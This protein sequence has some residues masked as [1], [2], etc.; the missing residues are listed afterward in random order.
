MGEYQAWAATGM[1][2]GLESWSE[3]DFGPEAGSDV[4]DVGAVRIASRMVE[5][6]KFYLRQ[7]DGRDIEVNLTDCGLLLRDGHTATAIWAAS[8]GADHGFCLYLENHTTGA[9]TRL[10]HNIQHI[11]TKVGLARTAKYGLFATAPAAVAML[12]W[13]MIPGTLDQIDL[14]WFILGATAALVVLFVIGLI[15]A[16]LVLDYF[17]ADDDQKVWQAVNDILAQVR[18]PPRQPAHPLTRGKL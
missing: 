13:L 6:Q 5:R 2:A 1:V 15:V 12:L 11:R 9:D 14:N 4:V 7:R 10:P 3:P 8:K 18:A 16:K 17:Q